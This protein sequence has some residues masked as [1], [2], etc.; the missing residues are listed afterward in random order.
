MRIESLRRSISACFLLFT[1]CLARLLAAQTPVTTSFTL[2]NPTP[3]YVDIVTGVVSLSGTTTTPTGTVSY[4]VDSGT[5]S[6]AT[7]SSGSAWLDIAPQAPGS[8]SV[9]WTYSGDGANQGASGSKSYTVSDL[10]AAAVSSSYPLRPVIYRQVEGNGYTSFG[11]SGVAV[12]ALGNTFLSF[13]SSSSGAAPSV[14]EI[15]SGLEFKVLPVSGIGTDTELALDA[16][17]NLYIADPTHSRIVEYTAGGVQQ[18]LGVSGLQT[19]VSL[20]YD[21][22]TNSLNIM[23]KGLG[24]VIR[25]DL[26]HSTQSTLFSVT[27]MDTPIAT[28]GQG[29]VYYGVGQHLYLWDGP[30][31]VH[32]IFG[33][34]DLPL[35]GVQQ[36]IQSIAYDVHQNVL[37]VAVA[38]SSSTATLFALDP[39]YHLLA[40]MDSGQD[41]AASSAQITTD[42]NGHAYG[43]SLVFT[44]GGAIN[45]GPVVN[46]QQGVQAWYSTPYAVAGGT[47]VSQAYSTQT[48]ENPHPSGTGFGAT[49][50]PFTLSIPGAAQQVNIPVYGKGYGVWDSVTPGSTANLQATV[51]QPGGI[52]NVDPFIGFGD[53]LYVTD[54]ANNSV[55]FLQW[56]PAQGGPIV[57]TN[58][59]LGFIGLQQ[60]TQVAA[61]GANDVWVHDKGGAGGSDRIVELN[62]AGVQSIAYP[63]NSATALPTVTALAQYGNNL[64]VAGSGGSG[65]GGMIERIDGVGNVLGITASIN[66]PVAIAV[67][68]DENI[69]SADAGGTLVRVDH[70]GKVTTVAS[71]LPPATQIS[72]LPNGTV[73]LSS[74]TGSDVLTIAPDGTQTHLAIPGTTNPAYAVADDQGNVS[75]VDGSNKS[76]NLNTRSEYVEQN[77]GSV[78]LNTTGKIDFTITNVGNLA[79]GELIGFNTGPFTL[80]GAGASP[81]VLTGSTSLIPGQSCGL[82]MQYVPTK[83]QTDAGQVG[84]QS[85]VSGVSGCCDVLS[86][87]FDVMGKGGN[88]VTAP[89]MVLTPPSIDFGSIALNVTASA[90]VATLSN[91][92]NAAQNLMNINI[93]GGNAASF[94]ETNNCGASVGA[95]SSCAISITCTPGFAGKLTAILN[96]NY[97]SPQLQQTVAL[98]CTGAATST[99]QAALTPSSADFGIETVGS[100]SASKTFMLMNAGNAALPVSSISITGANA[101]AYIIGS[102]NCGTSLG[103]GA[104]CAI[105]ISYKAATSGAATAT[106]TV[107]DGVGTQTSSLTATGAAVGTPDFTISAT[108]SSQ[109]ATRG[110][111]VSY[112]VQIAPAN[113]AQPFTNVVAL[114]AIGLPAGATATFTPASVTPGTSPATSTLTVTTAAQSAQADRQLRPILA[115]VSAASVLCLFG[116]AGMHR[117][118]GLRLMLVLLLSFAGI[119]SVLTG[120]GSGTGFAVPGATTNSTTST[121]TISGTSGS[122]VHTA[123]V[124]LTLQ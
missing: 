1:C 12:D 86:D 63:S 38:G 33:Q 10:P 108:P 121:I 75:F 104:S 76:V 95:G 35:P 4:K 68:A 64:Y 72:V 61:D 25:Y 105:A 34:F 18:A 114:T 120:C 106:L 113:T 58:K 69:Y 80:V 40:F 88:A 91:T 65:G 96:V 62:S 15:T 13:G 66:V 19:P 98:T 11:A 117:R 102:N 14:A 17:G 2:L 28:D 45:G 37:W 116:L 41:T 30:N 67:D 20:T 5:S 107:V 23:D 3:T 49:S 52:A 89:N 109:T 84:L 90:Q 103:A 71:S 51:S 92:G 77:F 8:H 53:D 50:W 44:V 82:E 101:S 81:C 24:A 31:V 73:Y 118:R 99:P 119:A 42:S 27:G 122:T 87:L 100:T 85:V 29:D 79:V 115:G 32:E 48:V 83:V 94:A 22:G 36:T 93:V 7:V 97:P 112:T 110:A 74:A 56:T 70:A 21:A 123:T 16:A 39:K 59:T 111:T 124:T 43:T 9:S 57:Y 60:P 78:A 26:A 55:T 6:T 54:T 47:T 46:L